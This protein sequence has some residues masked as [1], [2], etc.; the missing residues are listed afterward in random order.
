MGDPRLSQLGK[1]TFFTVY[2][3]A[4]TFSELWL[5]FCLKVMNKR[6]STNINRMFI[7]MF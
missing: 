2:N 5:I 6:S 3:R 4:I 7:Q 1:R